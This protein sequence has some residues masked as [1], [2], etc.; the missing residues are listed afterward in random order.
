MWA[1]GLAGG[2]L[3]LG[4]ALAGP[5]MGDPTSWFGGQPAPG[6]SAKKVTDTAR[7]PQQPGAG[8]K[9]ATVTKVASVP[10]QPANAHPEKAGKPTQVRGA[11]ETRKGVNGADTSAKR[12]DGTRR[13]GADRAGGRRD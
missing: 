10:K 12:Q 2:T 13:S 11:K 6:A 7:V 1:A 4:V 5:A 8:A 3:V 9:A